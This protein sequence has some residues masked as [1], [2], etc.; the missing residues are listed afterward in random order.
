MVRISAYPQLRLIAW[1]RCPDDFIDEE[2]AFALYEAYW[3]FVD[4][5]TMTESEHAFLKRIVN[6]FGKGLLNV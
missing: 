6:D 5:E 1:N 3:R 2:E 4:P